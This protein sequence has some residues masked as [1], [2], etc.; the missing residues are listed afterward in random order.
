MTNT[1]KEIELIWLSFSRTGIRHKRNRTTWSCSVTAF[2][3]S[4]SKRWASS[5]HV[6]GKQDRSIMVWVLVC[7][8]E[9]QYA[10]QLI[11]PDCQEQNEE[12]EVPDLETAHEQAA[13]CQEM[14]AFQGKWLCIQGLFE[15]GPA[16]RR[17]PLR[18]K[19][20]LCVRGN[21]RR[22][23][24][25]LWV[26]L[27]VQRQTPASFART[28]PAGTGDVLTR[29]T[30]VDCPSLKVSSTSN[31][32]HNGFMSSA[33]RP[34]MEVGEKKLISVPH[35]KREDPNAK[36]ASRRLATA[37]RSVACVLQ[38]MLV[39]APPP[40][41]H[42]TFRLCSTLPLQSDSTFSLYQEVLLSIQSFCRQ[43]IILV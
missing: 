26:A 29:G 16:G 36:L 7:L 41:V 27:M 21:T 3:G 34:A 19:L 9:T 42:L 24:L 31:H 39:T 32:V 1:K 8:G 11:E 5:L 38:L 35:D 22:A 37:L 40:T 14:H 15:P 18:Q 43:R 23:S 10:R 4:S 13:F 2:D 33:G 20:T 6:P 30:H 17:A 28:G 25:A 12:D